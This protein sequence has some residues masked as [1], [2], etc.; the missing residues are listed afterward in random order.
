MQIID[1]YKDSY[2]SYG[3]MLSTKQDHLDPAA[4]DYS[5]I[6]YLRKSM[7]ACKFDST[8]SDVRQKE[9]FMN[10][11]RF[12]E[13]KRDYFTVS[14][15]QVNHLIQIDEKPNLEIM[16]PKWELYKIS[17]SFPPIRKFHKI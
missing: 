16:E 15:R 8:P 13:T 9:G 3:Y 7:V 10:L 12:H 4:K 2:V 17:I 14:L 5:Y 6:E 11:I 1:H